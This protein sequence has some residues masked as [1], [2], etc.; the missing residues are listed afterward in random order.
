VKICEYGCGRE[1]KHQFKNGRWC[2]SK[3]W[4]QCPVEREKA[5][6]RIKE[7]WKNSKSRLN[8]KLCRKRK[9]KK[10]KKIRENPDS[11]FNSTWYKKKKKYGK[12]QIVYLIQ[13][14]IKRK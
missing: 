10:M 2:C 12:I 14:G 1:A 3:D 6:I 8:S 11:I 5:S 7:A 9:S 13:L 4:T